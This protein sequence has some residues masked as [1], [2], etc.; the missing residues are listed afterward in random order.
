MPRQHRRERPKTVIQPVAFHH[1]ENATGCKTGKNV[2][3]R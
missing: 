1:D 2:L 3:D